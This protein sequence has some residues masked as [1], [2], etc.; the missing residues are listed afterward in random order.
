[1][2]MT[3]STRNTTATHLPERGK[4]HTQQRCKG[5][6]HLT[7][8][9][10]F[11]L[12]LLVIWPDS[13]NAQATTPPPFIS[14]DEPAP[15][16][17]TWKI[18]TTHRVIEQVLPIQSLS[19][20]AL[21][22]R[23]IGGLYIYTPESGQITLLNTIDGKYDIA[24]TTM[25]V[26]NDGRFIW[27]GYNDG[28][29]SV[30]DLH[31]FRFRHYNDISRNTRFF[32]NRINTLVTDG[33]TLYAGTD[34]GVVVFDT[35]N[36]IIVDSFTR[37]G[38]LPSSAAV[39]SI[40]VDN[41]VLYLGTSGGV[42]VGNPAQSDLK[43]TES[44]V[45]Y[46]GQSDR[47][48]GSIEAIAAQNGIIYAST[49]N[50]N[51]RFDG[52]SW[53]EQINLGIHPVR[54]FS[55]HST[56]RW[57]AVT[58]NNIY[59]INPTA[60]TTELVRSV[61]FTTRFTTIYRLGN[62][63]FAGTE[64]QGLA[65]W[66][67][68]I[69]EINYLE[70]NGPSHNFFEEFVVTENGELAGA[71]S[72]TPERSFV[73]FFDTGFYIYKNGT[74]E[75][76]NSQTIEFLQQREARAFFTAAASGDQYFFGSWGPGLYRLNRSSGEITAYTPQNTPMVG[77]QS[78]ANY[79][80]ITGLTTDRNDSDHIWVVSWTN[81]STPL[82][83]YSISRD[84]W[85]TYPL[86]PETQAGNRYRRIMTDSY[87]Q[88]WITL[89][90]ETEAGRGVLVVRNP[91]GGPD[92]AFRL[93][94]NIESGN[95]PNDKANVIIQDRRGEVW[96]GTD[97]GIARYLFPD[98]I[99]TGSAAERRAQPLINRDTTAADRVLLRDVRVRALAVD[100]N[101][102]KWV[103]S[104]GD[105]LYLIEESG[106]EVIRHFTTENS[107]LPSNVIQSVTVNPATGE[108]YISTQNGFVV[109]QAL[110]REG[111]VSMKNLRLYPNP[112]SYKDHAPGAIVIEELADNATV[113]ILSA[114]G[115]M[116]RRFTTRGGRAEWDGL[117]QDRR[118]VPTGVYFV[119]ATGNNNDQVARGRV[120][121]VR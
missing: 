49:E 39:L 43:L 108:V 34:F 107:P 86:L 60:G 78:G 46:P 1:M 75:N 69:D 109:Y 117:D 95:L 9:L 99:V 116:V 19:G 80:I 31:T 92:S 115:R 82:A 87:G 118:Q 20:P 23:T 113:S 21:A 30:L 44:W 22:V 110:E 51:F 16:Y 103:G 8:I 25:T 63:L 58:F 4:C 85:T 45:T 18:Y 97:R 56:D 3:K 41:G 52:T 74:W 83:R 14:T 88:L 7:D 121:I 71:S 79:L 50:Q 68:P 40:D 102:Q 111:V 55:K 114:D 42:A 27:L 120:V 96:I 104:D 101:N 67:T 13:I 28:T 59:A 91:E 112:Y 17:D 70:P 84:E 94:T 5:I 89:L 32:S 35:N 53:T 72:T 64:R 73:G 29:L 48:N 12:L 36:R 24:A 37:F 76:F 66:Q 6:R 77:F 47:F 26:S 61:P 38:E 65:S 33:Q 98:R 119:V 93:T 15:P 10:S 62:T 54:N 11:L 106:R 2:L 90:T 81:L 100:A 105:G 57:Y